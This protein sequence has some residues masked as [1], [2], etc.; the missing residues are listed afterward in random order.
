MSIRYIACDCTEQHPNSPFV[1]EEGVTLHRLVTITDHKTEKLMFRCMLCGKDHK[2]DS[3]HV[4]KKRA[5][6]REP[7]KGP[8]SKN[9][10]IQKPPKNK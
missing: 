7:P 8:K 6:E 9:P 5:W 3:K 4:P 2:L 10:N 1:V